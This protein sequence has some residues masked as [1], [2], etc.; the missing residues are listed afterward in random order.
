MTY[1]FMPVH[2]GSYLRDTQHLSLSEQGTYFLLLMHCWDTK[3]PAPL[4]EIRLC[5]IVNARSDD[6]VAS[7]RRVLDEFFI[8][9]DDGWH[10][11]RRYDSAGE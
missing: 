9:G 10:N 11:S 2:T 5:S 3:G 1:P 8:R 6:E 7:L 4:D